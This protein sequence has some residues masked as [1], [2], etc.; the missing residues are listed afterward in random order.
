MDTTQK[1]LRAL[2]KAMKE[3]GID[4]CVIPATDPHL[5]EYVP[6]HWKIIRWLTGFTGS[7]A[8]IVITHTFAGL[9][10]DSRYFIQAE[11]QLSGSGFELFK[12]RIPH[13]PEYIDWLAVNLRKNSVV[14]IDGRVYATGLHKKMEKALA[15]KSISVDISVD[16][17]SALWI[18]RP[19]M[20]SSQAFEHTPEF[21]GL[22]REE[23][24]S[25]VRSR[26]AEI[27]VDHHLLT[28][29]DDIMWLLNIRGSDVQFCPLIICYALITPGQLLLFVNE[30]QIPQPLRRDFDRAGV[31][32]LPYEET[33]TI[34][35][36]LSRRT[37]L[38][39]NPSTTSAALYSSVGSDV[40]VTEDVT[41]PTRLKAIKNITE[42]MN[43]RQTMIKD[44][45]ALTKF[46]FWFESAV[47]RERVT[48]ISA[49][50]KLLQFRMDQ[51]GCCGA[52]FETISAWNAHAALP[53]YAPSEENET[54]IA[55]T[56]IYLLDS[57]GQYHGGTTDVTRCTVFGEPTAR[58]K[59]D[60]TL[61]LKGTI[62]L[63]MV[64][65][66][67]G[68]RGYQVEILA[69][70]ALWDNGLNYGHGTGHGVGYFLNV[71]EGPQTIGT[72]AS[73]DL[74]TILEPGMLT[75]DEPAIYRP[76]EYGFRTENLLLCVDDELTEYGQFLRFETV[77]LCYIEKKLID[78]S[79]LTGEERKWI[80]N[81]HRQVFASLADKLTEEEK[82]W[83]REKTTPLP[84]S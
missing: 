6:D 41:V 53:H 13:T 34:M 71:H 45:V 11:Q 42:I 50:E 70:K 36:K 15:S 75:A 77:T 27:G 38:L 3:S 8:N 33:A 23:K 22:S 17:I 72:G 18:D 28:S 54:D 67:L 25:R 55:G 57:G 48:E 69:R 84:V 81:Y 66:P 51:K 74:K 39:L 63:A 35:R 14:G 1:R 65:F 4:A 9:W 16:L 79:V 78:V 5:G 20:P 40:E 47:G 21:T 64:K 24:I 43:I 83:L 68:T 46:F 32:M 7:A 52:S 26:M 60:F 12:L 37:S 58:Q 31:V 10:T 2:R 30:E 49:A 73:G 59:R 62:A 56:G 29:P 19:S 80:D 44:G 61:A 82:E 76:G